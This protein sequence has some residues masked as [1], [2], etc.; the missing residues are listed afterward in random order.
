MPI[1][2]S[3]C[4]HILKLH[5]LHAATPQITTTWCCHLWFQSLNPHLAAPSSVSSWQKLHLARFSNLKGE[6]SALLPHLT[7]GALKFIRRTI[8]PS[9]GSALHQVW[10]QK[11]PGLQTFWLWKLTHVL[12]TFSSTNFLYYRPHG[13]KVFK[14]RFQS[15]TA[16][17]VPQSMLTAVFNMFKHSAI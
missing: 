8:S 15:K 16:F 2:C 17:T 7:S 9:S 12:R 11:K 4:S 3:F 1:G 13:Y 10:Q 6:F 14:L 5:L